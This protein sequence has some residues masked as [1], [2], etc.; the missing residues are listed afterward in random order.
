MSAS[1]PRTRRCSRSNDLV[2][3]LSGPP[4]AGRRAAAPAA[5]S[6]FTPSTASPSRSARGEMLA[7][8]GESGCGKTTTAQTMLRLVDPVSGIDP[9]R[10]RDITHLSRAAICARSA[11]GCR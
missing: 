4:R 3:T 11:G 8:V 7:L 2:V 6:R 10:G 5:A 9:F 1:G